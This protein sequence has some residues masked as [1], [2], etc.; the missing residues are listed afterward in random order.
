M[1]P[2]IYEKNVTP[3]KRTIVPRNISTGLIGYKSPYPTT[4]SV[5]IDQ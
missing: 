3:P 2:I 4:E 1:D 5:V